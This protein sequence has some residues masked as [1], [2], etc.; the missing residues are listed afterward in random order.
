MSTDEDAAVRR[1]ALR[2]FFA[3]ANVHQAVWGLIV[4]GVAFGAGFCSDQIRSIGKPAPSTPLKASDTLMVRVTGGSAARDSVM[5]VRLDSIA[6]QLGRVL[7]GVR[8]D[9]VASVRPGARPSTTAHVLDSALAD[10]NRLL[11]STPTGTILLDSAEAANMRLNQVKRPR[12]KYPG[13][14]SAYQQGR[15]ITV[16]HIECPPLR[17]NRGA[18]VLTRI[19][20]RPELDSLSPLVLSIH[21]RTSP[22]AVDLLFTEQFELRPGEN[23]IGF[24]ANVPE[25]R[26]ELELLAYSLRNVGRAPPL[27]YRQLCPLEVHVPPATGSPTR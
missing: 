25:G 11:G 15:L 27:E 9:S 10:I 12:F 5:A 1:S 6:A 21:R 13:S 14:V 24:R 2:E 19:V 20:V 17:I 22:N 8:N 16:A 18:L 23:L 7:T 26:Y 4:A 3:P